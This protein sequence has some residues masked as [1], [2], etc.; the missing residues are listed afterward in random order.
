METE[1][2]YPDDSLLRKA[3]GANAAFSGLSGLILLLAAEPISRL[4][5]SVPTLWLYAIGGMLALF[6]LHLW[7][8]VRAKEIDPGQA[9]GASV[10]DLAWVVGSAALLIL[11][12]DVFSGEGLL[13]VAVVALIVLG[14]AVSQLAG[15]RRLGVSRAG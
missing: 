4:L 10:A 12:P 9:L 1:N 3:L 14:M 8:Q 6:S 2:L 13:L 11:E 5:G 7:L 15:L